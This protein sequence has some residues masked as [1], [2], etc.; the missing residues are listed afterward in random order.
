MVLLSSVLL[1]VA[2]RRQEDGL[3]ATYGSRGLA[4]LALDALLAVRWVGFLSLLLLVAVGYLGLDWGELATAWGR[5]TD[6]IVRGASIRVTMNA[7]GI[8]LH[9][10]VRPLNQHGA[11]AAA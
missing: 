9:V 5:V 8:H 4:G 7:T 1:F 10:D 11:A 2:M 6:T 3:V